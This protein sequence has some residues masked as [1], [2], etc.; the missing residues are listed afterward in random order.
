[1]PPTLCSEI[2]RFDAF[3]KEKKKR[4]RHTWF[5]KETRACEKKVGGWWRH[6]C[7]IVHPP[8][9]Q[10]RRQDY[11]N[12]GTEKENGKETNNEMQK[13]EKERKISPFISPRRIKSRPLDHVQYAS[14]VGGSE[15]RSTVGIKGFF[16]IRTNNRNL[17]KGK[18]RI[19]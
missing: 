1:M 8:Q 16:R 9:Q 7:S 13:S 10:H 12:R 14:T 6:Y 4:Q 11:K 2:E 3:T 17:E 5:V 18:H 15:T 19:P